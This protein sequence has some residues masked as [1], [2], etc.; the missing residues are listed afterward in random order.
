MNTSDNGIEFIKNEEGHKLYVYRDS[1]GN[2]TCGYGHLVVPGD[3]LQVG[4]TITQE[5]A[6]QFFLDDLV[7]STEGPINDLD[8]ASD[9]S[10]NQF[11][12]L[13]SIVFNGGSGVL[14][15]HD[16]RN[17]FNYPEIFPDFYGPLSDDE[18]DT[19]SRLVSKAFSYDRS[20]KGRRNREATLFCQGELYT[21]QYPVYTL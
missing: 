13:A 18:I 20:L 14:Q 17:M 4:D 3:N 12:A 19:C 2:P 21:H 7:N 9:L 15:T 11:D 6:D 5:Q 16:M 8:C 10:Q 1:K